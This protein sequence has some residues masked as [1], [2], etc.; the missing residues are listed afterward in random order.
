MRFCTNEINGKEE[1]ERKMKKKTLI[2]IIAVALVLCVSVGG[3]LAWLQHKT[4]TE[5]NTFTVGNIGLTLG[6]T[7]GNDYKIIPGQNLAKDPKVTVTS[8]SE[9]CYVFVKVDEANWPQFID[10]DGNL[11]VSYAI[12]DGWTELEGT[13]NIYY[14]TVNAISAD[15]A[16]YV[17][18]DNEIKVSGE[19]TKEELQQI[20]TNPT[21][22]FTAY[23]IQQAGFKTVADAW[24]AVNK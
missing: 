1:K 23:A 9:A 22:A 8:G 18:K 20:K 4:Q 6:E 15:T 11:K 17:L 21:L 5:T 10:A 13:T 14:R 24:T 7:T 16:F 2:S 19:L 3:V 12:A